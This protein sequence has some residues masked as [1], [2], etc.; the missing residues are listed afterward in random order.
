M[1]YLLKVFGT[2]SIII[3]F[4]A[5]CGLCLQKAKLTT[6]IK[7]TVLAFLGFVLIKTGG[8][9]L[10]GVLTMFSDLFTH[11]F[12]LRGV[13]PS[14]E[15]IMALTI[16]RL[17]RPAA[18]I[19][20]FAMIINILLARYTRFKSIYL[21]LHL[22]VFMA[23]SVTAALVGL[24]YSELFSIV[25]G[26]V[27]IGVYMAVFP[28]VLSRFSRKIIGHNDYCIAHAA[29]SSYLI[30]SFLGKWFGNTS[31]NVEH[32]NVSDKFSFLKNSDVAT[33]LTMF[34][35]LGVSSLFS[36]NEYLV[37]IMEKKPYLVWLLEKSAVFAGG[38][39]IAKKGVVLFAEEI[40]PAFKGISQTIAPGSIPAVDPMVL[41]DKSP[42]AVLI[43]FL[44][45]FFAELCCIAI[46]PSLGLPIIVPG[47]LASFTCGGTAA[48]FGNATGGLR[49]AIIASFVNGLLLCFLPALVLPLFSY[50]G[51]TGVTF[52]DP[53]FTILS[54]FIK[55]TFGLV[56]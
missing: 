25:F 32:V 51:A 15:A 56:H 28:T 26:S 16:D 17:G 7:G 35:L 54:A 39:F 2:P 10:G 48:I 8:G 4:I 18:I 40:V 34:C 33:F 49:G 20:F 9:I 41:F 36:S 21:S 30:A 46:F 12:G 6:I 37:S 5:F 55:Y 1:D 31:V 27:V 52:A 53:D 13:V 11:A 42:N 38:L 50:L 43:G 19:L 3:A 14:N 23:F 47:I 45:S 44:V 29:S 22:I 24:G